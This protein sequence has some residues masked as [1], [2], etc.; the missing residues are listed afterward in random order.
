MKEFVLFNPTK[1][2]F[3]C[4]MLEK[5][6]KEAKKLGKK[7]IIITGKTS[8][9]QTGVLDRVASILTQN[10]FELVI[11]SKITPNPKVEEVD[12]AA[13]IAKEN[14]CDF[15]IGLGGGSAMD[16][17]KGVAIVAKN[18]GSIWDYIPL[19]TKKAKPFNEVL[20]IMMIPTLAATSSE[21]NCAAVFT[22]LATNQ[23]AA[24][25][26]P[27]IY[28]KISIVDPLLTITVPKKQTA[29]GVI[30]IIMHV[31]EEYLT[32]DENCDLQDR[33]TEGIIVTCIE[34]AKVLMQEPQNVIA[35]TNISFCSLV[36][37]HGFPN[38]GRSGVWNV[39]QIEH[40][41]TGLFDNISH[42]S[43]IAA[44]LPAYLKF[45]SQKRKNK[46]I[47]LAIN[48]FGLDKNLGDE[49]LVDGCIEKFK[50]FINSIG[51]STDLKSLGI[52]REDF[53]R[54]VDNLYSVSGFNEIIDNKENVIKILELAYE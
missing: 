18:G 9:K 26:N 33:I 4:G 34:N 17:A 12:E 45:L 24:I 19:A 27:L 50:E 52:K 41:I 38:A 48:V 36:A 42:G 29:E 32:G 49:K 54:I 39:H 14:N 37:L 1:I 51:L 22:N 25:V 21:V 28:P 43:G 16:A 46:V 8:A 6:G 7:P 2:L 35:R 13:K 53:G 31:L 15:V 11:Y 47:Q 44:V 10:G 5:C 20:P 23:K 3:G 40:A 30:D